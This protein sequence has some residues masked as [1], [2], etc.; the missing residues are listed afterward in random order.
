MRKEKLESAIRLMKRAGLNSGWVKM[1]AKLDDGK[2]VFMK[3]FVPGLVQ[4]IIGD[5]G[6]MRF[7][8]VQRRGITANGRSISV[9]YDE[10]ECGSGGPGPE[11]RLT[12]VEQREVEKYVSAFMRNRMYLN[13]NVKN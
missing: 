7:M 6:N 12:R 11:T 5:G 10:K 1:E 13:E 3:Y 8:Y 2:F 4:N 9:E